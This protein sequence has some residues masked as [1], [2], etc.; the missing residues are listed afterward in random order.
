[1]NHLETFISYAGKVLK[2]KKNEKFT[3]ALKLFFRLLL[4]KKDDTFFLTVD[5]HFPSL[6]IEKKTK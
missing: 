3:A 1:M 2:V 5:N 6:P 4:E